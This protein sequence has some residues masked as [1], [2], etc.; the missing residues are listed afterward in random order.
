MKI[1]LFSFLMDCRRDVM[2]RSKQ[3]IFGSESGI[4]ILHLGLSLAHLCQLLLKQ[5]VS[6]RQIL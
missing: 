6:I 1:T 5:V 2:Q 4:G 3:Q